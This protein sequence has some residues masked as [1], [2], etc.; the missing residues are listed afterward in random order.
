MASWAIHFRI[1]D[2]FLERIPNLNKEYFIIGNIA[3]DCGVPFKEKRGYDPPSEI[4]HYAKDGHKSDCDYDFIYN[5][6]I[7]NEIDINKK[8]FYIGYF[9]H[10]MTD[11]A[12]VND[13][14]YSIVKEYGHLSANR[15]LSRAV[16]RE[17]YNLDFLYFKNNTSKSFELF[18]TY[19]GFNEPYPDFYKKNEISNRMEYIVSFYNSNEPEQMT[20]KYTPPEMVEGFVSRMPQ[21][22]YNELIKRNVKL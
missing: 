5:E 16:K 15:E 1:A 2:W 14:T 21:I 11:C 17:W 8:S 20:Y 22:I 12:F 3:P 7:K 19:D 13:I 4:T 9:V 10:L 18:K 6:F